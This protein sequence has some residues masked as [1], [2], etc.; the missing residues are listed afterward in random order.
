[1]VSGTGDARLRGRTNL[2]SL[3]CESR[4]RAVSLPVCPRPQHCSG[5]SNRA[6]L[7]GGD[8]G[9]NLQDKDCSPT[10]AELR[11]QRQVLL[12]CCKLPPQVGRVEQQNW[13]LQVRC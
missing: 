5:V 4:H 13:P 7:F 11:V 9:P 2:L 12:V 10:K 6:S 8:M 3:S 1:M